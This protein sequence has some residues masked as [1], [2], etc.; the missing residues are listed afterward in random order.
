MVAVRGSVLAVKELGP[1]VIEKRLGAEWLAGHA[2]TK[3]IGS[4]ALAMPMD[5]L[6]KPS[7]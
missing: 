5:V 1:Q 3:I 7:C 6:A 2:L 4:I